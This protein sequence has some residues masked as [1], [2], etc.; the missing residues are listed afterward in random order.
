MVPLQ[1]IDSRTQPNSS[2]AGNS[3]CSR[4]SS[5]QPFFFGVVPPHCLKWK[6]MPLRAHWSRSER[7]QSGSVRRWC[8]PLSPP[9]M[10]QSGRAVPMAIGPSNGSA[11]TPRHAAGVRA[12]FG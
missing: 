5:E 7:T 6:A 9:V 10:I 3:L 12:S 4:P 8:G 2:R 11:E 1:I